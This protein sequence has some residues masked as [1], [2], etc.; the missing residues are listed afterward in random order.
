MLSKKMAFS[1]MSLITLLSLAFVVPSAMAADP[2]KVTVEGRTAVNHEVNDQSA[3]ADTAVNLKI[4]TDQPVA[5]AL[6][7]TTPQ[8]TNPLGL[9][10]ATF[11]KDGLAVAT[12]ATVALDTDTDVMALNTA[13]VRYYVVSVPSGAI[14][15]DTLPLRVVVTVPALTSSDVTADVLASKVAYHTITVSAYVD[16]SGIPKV[17]SIQRL[18]PGSQTVVAAFQE[19][20]IEPEPF[21]VRVVLSAPP[22]GIDLAAAANLVEV[23]NGVASNIVIGVPF[24]RFGGEADGVTTVDPEKTIRPSPIEGMYEHDGLLGLAGVLPGVVGSGNVPLPNDVDD[25]YRQYRVTITPHIKSANFDIKVKVKTFHD[26][27]AV[28]RTTYLPPGFGDSV[29]LPNGRNILTIPVK[30]A[31]RDRTAGYKVILPEKI[32]IPA[33]G[34]LV[35]AQDE[36]GSEVVVPPGKR[37]ESPKATERTPAQMLYNV[38]VTVDLPNLATAFL[39]GVVVDVESQHPLV[40]SE[41]MW[42]EDTSLNTSSNSQYIELYNPGGEYKTINDKDETPD[43]NEAL[44]LIFYA[45][46]EFDAIPAV[47]AAGDLA[48]GLT[49]RIGTLD[50]K[51]T[52][53]SPAS[54]GQSGRSGTLTAT[55]ATLQ[56][57]VVNLCL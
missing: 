29:H 1:L 25:M 10:I 43:V 30:G 9:T 42:G 2:F 3:A 38:Y 17:V 54:K 50:A 53:W 28:V 15:E 49:D 41:V 20:R 32:V 34:Y 4:T 40:I 27:G 13:R 19:E 39:N 56:Q 36:D 8:T 26:N 6:D 14:T 31:A 51:G 47:D 55:E 37:D 18:R 5:I 44:T 45:P 48:T 23:E 46:N 7:D 33:G 11:G 57:N 24:A 21:N 16:T 35:I 22:H 52:Y 12:P